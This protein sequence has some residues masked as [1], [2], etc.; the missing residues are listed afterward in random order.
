MF[1]PV[2]IAAAALAIVGSSIV[3]AQQRLGEAGGSGNVGPRFEHRQR[4]SAED[5]AAFTDARIAALKAGLEL[6]PD[7]AQKW[8][9]FEQALRDLAQLRM[10]RMQARGASPHED[11]ATAA[12][13]NPFDR[14]ARRA[15]N[16]S[17]KSTVLKRIADAGAP[18]Y[19][20][21]SDS[22]KH[23]FKILAHMLRPHH[24][25]AGNEGD[26]HGWR[27]GY[28]YGSEENGGDGWRQFQRHRLGENDRGPGGMRSF[29]QNEEQGSEL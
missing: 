19:E 8:P 7:Q 1:K 4:P 12:A 5:M 26:H 9:P 13:T 22:Q 3:Y 14:L 29:M 16:M 28:G 25:F 24:R 15:D 6:T 18:L 17:Q 27:Q 20:S 21:L 10:E 11:D 23:R 2:I